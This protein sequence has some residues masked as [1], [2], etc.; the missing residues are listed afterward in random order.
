MVRAMKQLILASTNP[1]K[2]KAALNGFERMFPDAVFALRSVDVPSGVSAQPMSDDETYRGA[3][4]RAR[5]AREKAANGDYWIG[6]EGGIEDG[7]HGMIA[8][9]WI[10]V[11]SRDRQGE[12]R[13]ATFALPSRVAEL[14]RQG[15]ELGEADD[16]V[17]A[18]TSSKT[19]NGAVGL[20]TAEVIDR[21]A[22]YEPA[23]IL[24]LIPFRNQELF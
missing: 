17:F 6:F 19:K 23:V 7:E 8:F 2:Q 4:N 10:V 9:A 22:L 16:I 1:V 15:T 11:L 20:L 13:S 3:L 12:S 24:A 14:V 21:V 18:R 5:R